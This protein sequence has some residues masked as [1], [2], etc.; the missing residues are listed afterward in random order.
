MKLLNLELKTIDLKQDLFESGDFKSALPFIFD[1]DMINEDLLIKM[2]EVNDHQEAISYFLACS[3]ITEILI[4]LKEVQKTPN[5]Q[6]VYNMV[7]SH[8]RDNTRIFIDDIHEKVNYGIYK[9][10]YDFCLDGKPLMFLSRVYNKFFLIYEPN[11]LTEFTTEE[12]VKIL[13]RTI[14]KHIIFE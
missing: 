6:Y 11:R 10:L 13:R 8:L 3:I 7:Y 14:K 1:E 2:L 5:E 4:E 9:I 12:V